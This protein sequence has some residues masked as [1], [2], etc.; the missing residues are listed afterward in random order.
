MNSFYSII[1]NKFT[2]LQ[3]SQ[4]DST[5]FAYPG[6]GKMPFL[7]TGKLLSD[8]VVGIPQIN[9]VRKSISYG[10]FTFSES[11]FGQINSVKLIIASI[12]LLA[13]KAIFRWVYQQPAKAW[14]A[15]KSKPLRA[16]YILNIMFDTL[17][18]QR[19]RVVQG[20]AFY[21]DAIM[22]ADV[23]SACLMN[24][25]PRDFPKL[26]QGALASIMLGI[27]ARLPSA[28]MEMVGDFGSCIQKFTTIAPALTKSINDQLTRDISVKIDEKQSRWDELSAQCDTM[29]EIA[30]RVPGKWHNMYLPYSNLLN[31]KV[32][33]TIGVFLEGMVSEEDFKRERRSVKG[34]RTHEDPVWQDTFFELV[35]EIKFRKKIMENLLQATRNLNFS[36]VVFPHCDYVSYAK[37]HADLN[38]DIRR[39]SER[40]RMVKNAFDENTFQEVGSI[41]L[42]LAIQA[43]ASESK[44]NDIFTRDEELLKEETWS[45][46]ID[47]SK[48]LSGSGSELRAISIC[49]AETAHAI[50]GTSP[51]GMFAFSDELACIKHY[52]EGYDNLIKA[53]IGG[54]RMSGLSHIPDA[55][56]AC[57]NLAKP[58]SKDHNFMILISDGL[59]SGYSHIEEEFATA[60]KELKSH[61]IDLIAMGIGSAS[62]KKTVRNARVVEK[63]ADIAKQ[64]MDIYMSLSS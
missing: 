36:D 44:R 63:P 26:E 54:L 23:L 27:P 41:D 30:A 51:W 11:D 3:I 6:D 22:T 64:F 28:V 4:V 37:M 48:S 12:S 49:L 32:P 10:P 7:R 60:V 47:A 1:Y 53:R 46:L 55:I 5:R 38:P 61:G 21:N 33:D 43:V 2:E 40:V 62:I 14:L 20:D 29:Y 50:L 56:R 9:L 35:R 42:Q 18:R 19:I 16:R 24:R 57:A 31:P 58:H 8:C 39:M 25:N 17:A 34:L 59:P 52:A 13:S 45:I 15:K